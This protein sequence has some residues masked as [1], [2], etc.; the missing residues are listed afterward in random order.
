MNSE[1]LAAPSSPF[2]FFA[3]CDAKTIEALNRSCNSL[4]LNPE[5]AC[6]LAALSAEM[7]Q[8]TKFAKLA[9]SIL[10]LPSRC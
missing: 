5:S 10:P 2:G 3:K 9:A 1:T 6:G 4:A 8:H 7:E